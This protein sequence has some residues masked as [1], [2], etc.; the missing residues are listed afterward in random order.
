MT[1]PRI[2]FVRPDHLGDVL[3]T[4]PALA[5][6][7]DALP[8]AHIAFLVPADICQV[9]HR[10]PDIDET[11]T[12]RPSPI[13]LAPD[14]PHWMRIAASRGKELRGKFDLALLPRPDDPWSG[15]LVAAADIPARI[16]FAHPRT[17]P[18]L[19]TALP[20][21]N[22]CHVAV[23]GL[24]LA[25]AAATW[26]GAPR[27][28]HPGEAHRP[29]FVPTAEE[30]AEA[31]QVLSAT[32]GP[33]IA[34]IALHPGSSWPLKNWLP[35]RWGEVAAELARCYQTVP[36][37]TGGPAET[38]LVDAIVEASGGSACGVAGRLSLGGL[39]ALYQ[40][41]RL[42]IATDSG[43]LHLA[44]AVGT[45]VVGLYG[46]AGPLEFGPWCAEDRSR[47]VRVELPCSPCSTL[48]DPPC[49]A[50]VRPSC[51]TGISVDAVL[52]AAAELLV[53]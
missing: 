15:V 46:P 51:V 35:R 7:R 13:T 14:G 33:E 9:T 23:L 24:Q 3:L 39:A 20:V 29:R 42:L 4:L 37:V 40:R 45:P 2:L 50:S 43:P 22:R 8:Q 11:Y 47:V 19:T 41:A 1:R 31:S 52:S 53:G 6:L 26:L 18:F 16:G 17:L 38:S 10:C 44:A 34:P 30:E 27:V 12:V 48:T 32:I 36:L 49:G 21:P 5:A 28:I 25:A